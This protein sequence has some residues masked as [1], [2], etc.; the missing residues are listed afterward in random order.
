M[1]WP[2]TLN[3][4]MQGAPSFAKFVDTAR[5]QILG[6]S[7]LTEILLF[8]MVIYPCYLYC[9]LR[10]ICHEFRKLYIDIRMALQ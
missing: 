6:K 1:V 4:S 7:L 9:L 2:Y 3:E 10:Q 8:K 5:T